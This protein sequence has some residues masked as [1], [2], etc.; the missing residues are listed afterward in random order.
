MKEKAICI[1]FMPEKY[2]DARQM[3]K[4]VYEHNLFK[5]DLIDADMHVPALTV[6]DIRSIVAIRYPESDF[7]LEA[8]PNEHICVMIKAIRSQAMTP[9]EQALGRFT[10][11]KLKKLDTWPEWRAGEHKQ[12]DHFH[13]LDTESKE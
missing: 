3:R 8:I 12:L 2:L 4:V 1:E 13:D 10:R 11:Y 9:E 5:P 7:S 6:A